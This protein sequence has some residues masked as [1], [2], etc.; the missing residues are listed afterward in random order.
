MSIKNGSVS[1]SKTFD[2]VSFGDPVWS[3]RLHSEVV[4][5]PSLADGQRIENQDKDTD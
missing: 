1:T 2:D 5:S 3:C 4:E